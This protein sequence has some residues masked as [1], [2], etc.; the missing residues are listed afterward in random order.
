L[1]KNYTLGKIISLSL[2]I[3]HINDILRTFIRQERQEKSKVGYYGGNFMEGFLRRNNIFDLLVILLGYDMKLKPK[4][5][6][7]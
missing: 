4:R 7:K 3:F 2:V 1:L 5:K 6:A